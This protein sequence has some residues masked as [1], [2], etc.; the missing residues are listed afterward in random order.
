MSKPLV[1][2]MAQINPIVGAIEANRDKI[3]TIIEA[4]QT[5]HDVIIFPEL[6]LTGYPPEDLLLRD[7]CMFRVEQALTTICQAT[8]NTHVIIGHPYQENAACYNALSIIHEGQV[9]AIYKKQ[10]L[11]NTGV[12]DE[13]R[14]FE[15]GPEVPCLL[16]IQ[17][18]TIGFCICEDIW[19]AG[20]VEQMINAGA[21]IL[22]C[23]NASPFEV[24]KAKERI[25]L[26]QS[27]APNQLTCVY[28]NLVGAQDELVFD[29]QSFVCN[30]QGQIKAQAPAFIEHLHT[31]HIQKQHIQ[32]KC[33]KPLDAHAL[34]YKALC[35]GLS[36]YITKN[37]FPGVLLGLSGGIDSALTLAI[38]VDALGAERVHA[39]A[40]PSRYTSE[41]S[42]DDLH[43]I[44]ANV[45]GVQHDTL[46]IEPGFEALLGTLSP[47]LD[48][49]AVPEIAQQN[50]QARLR[51]MILMAFSNSNQ[52]LV[53]STSNKT[54]SAIGYTTLYGDMCGGFA[55]IQDVPKMLVYALV[56]YRN[57]VSQVIPERVLTRAPSAELADNQ[58]DQDNLPDYPELDQI[59]AYYMNEKLRT[60]QIIEKGHAPD[61]VKQVI[62]LIQQ[63]EYKRRQAPPGTKI[64]KRAFGRDWRYP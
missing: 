30:H 27:H 64:S 59:V 24:D 45:P 37:N 13:K 25:E 10:H 50:L 58:T 6:V 44:L 26:L 62:G 15:P 49:Q 56:R 1:F 28:V 20:P 54:E 33:E 43:E 19:N 34:I 12:F 41:M 8:K 35:T 31:V 7:A 48:N 11:P 17:N 16:T 4:H 14:Y 47:H 55:P 40:L 38:A 2:L 39:L 22:V 60:D 21:D 29:G 9:T 3:V 5:T 18:Q 53:L 51:G 36:D 61:A 42:T 32:S 52:K 46:S 57:T 63:N 23:I